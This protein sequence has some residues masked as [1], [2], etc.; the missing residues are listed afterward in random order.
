MGVV[1]NE[2]DYIINKYLINRIERILWKE[3]NNKADK[4]SLKYICM[5][6]C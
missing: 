2:K 4:G 5:V 6:E 3:I 1:R